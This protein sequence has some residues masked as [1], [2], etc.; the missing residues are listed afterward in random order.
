MASRCQRCYDDDMRT[1]VRLDDALLERLKAQARAEKVSL[2]RMLNRALKAGS[3]PEAHAATATALSGAGA[4]DGRSSRRPRQGAGDG[5]R[6]RRRGSRP[7]TRDT[8]VK[9]IDLNILLYAINAEAAQHQT[10][11]NGGSAPSTTATRRRAA[12]VVLLGFLR[13]STNPRVFPRPLT[14]DAA[15][16]KVDTWLALDNVRV[17]RE[18]DEHWEVLKSLLA[19]SGAA[20]NLT[21]DAHLAALALTHDAVLVSSDTDFARFRGLRLENALR[22]D[23]RLHRRGRLCR[24]WCTGPAQRPPIEV[25]CLGFGAI[26]FMTRAA[27]E[28]RR[29]QAIRS[30]AA[31]PVEANTR[32]VPSAESCGVRSSN[33]ETAASRADRVRQ[34]AGATRASSP[35]ARAVRRIGCRSP[36]VSE[37]HNHSSGRSGST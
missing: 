25:F 21:T 28:C 15:A 29:L 16:A 19:T 12:M 8:Q 33:V 7:R 6:A 35:P 23:L 27:L 18:K 2:T 3:T 22:G 36:Y 17:V 37:R 34:P 31:T 1:T 30:P 4:R 32:C 5:R 14:P 11:V 24:R 26:G 20:G 10:R 13:L 9:I